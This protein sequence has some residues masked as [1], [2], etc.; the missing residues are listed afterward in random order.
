MRPADEVRLLAWEILQRIE[1]SRAFADILLDQTFSQK[2]KLSPRD[3]AFIMELVLGTHRWR[4]RLDLSIAQAA[5][6]PQKKVNPR[7]LD[8]LRLATYQILFLD[9]VPNSAAVNESVLLAR[10]VF[11]D[12]KIVKF[13]NAILRAIARNQ[14]KVDFPPFS[15]QPVEYI[16]QALAHPRWMVERWVTQFGPEMARNFCQANNRR[17]PFTIRTNLLKIS[18]PALTEKLAAFGFP[19]FSTPFVPEGLILTELPSLAGDDLFA[20]G[21]YFVQ[22]EA[23]QAIAHLVD[24]QP[25]EKVLDACA[26]PGGKTTH[27]AQRMEN[28]GLIVALDLTEAKVRHI[29]E[30]CSRIG[31]AIVE[32]LRADATKPL[33]LSGGRL[34][35]RILVDAP[36]TGLGI[37]HRNPEVKWRRRPEDSRRL[38][39]LQLAILNN[40]ASYLKPGGI[41]V[42]STCTVTP[43]ENDQVVET[44]LQKHPAFQPEDL[45]S[46]V[47][48]QLHPLLDDRGLL[49]TYPEVT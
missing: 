27:L 25:G 1:H 39:A 9:R 35:D 15:G 4:S 17:P 28:Q 30:N 37:L 20:Q 23:S 19:S 48:Q 43:E 18:R 32:A 29:R 12:E 34:F 41:L 7:L 13:V 5:R 40:V 2:P 6:S 44:F 11:H 16:I 26:A 47:P 10:S 42:Y 33:P 49:R 22:D 3:R 24:P 31:I 21:M 36:C 14:G 45:H 38:Q 46:L 8:L